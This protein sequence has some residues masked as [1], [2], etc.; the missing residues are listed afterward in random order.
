[1]KTVKTARRRLQFDC[2]EDRSLPSGLIMGLAQ[3]T[4]VVEDSTTQSGDAA[5]SEAVVR[6]APA[7]TASDNTRPA[8]TQFTATQTA[9]VALADDLAPAPHPE[10]APEPEPTP[11]PTPEPAPGPTPRSDMKRTTATPVDTVDD[12][13]PAPPRDDTDRDAVGVGPMPAPTR[14]A[15]PTPP[16][17]DPVDGA[18]AAPGEAPALAAT[19]PTPSSHQ[20]AASQD[21][22]T[23]QPSAIANDVAAALARQQ[24]VADEAGVGAETP[25]RLD[26]ELA[27]LA[28]VSPALDASRLD[29]ALASFL[30]GL[31]DLGRQLL[32]APRDLGWPFWLVA[33]GL[34]SGAIEL[35][36]RQVGRRADQR[37]PRSVNPLDWTLIVSGQ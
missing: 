5:S 10:P 1:M 24:A 21:T 26:S 8:A 15:E 7:D 28:A 11:E 32:Q 27:M 14:D 20:G 36:R 12:T 31:E 6:D 16:S 30:D 35:G 3:P 25:D 13:D 17:S 34:V 2:L 23:A 4:P 9:P 18:D 29:A 19:P 37:K 22:P 33:A